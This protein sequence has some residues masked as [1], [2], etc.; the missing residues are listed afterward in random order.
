MDGK[1]LLGI[2]VIGVFLN[3]GFLFFMPEALV[4]FPTALV[5]ILFEGFIIVD[6]VVRP[7]SSKRDE[8]RRSRIFTVSLFLL[9]PILMLLPI[10][11]MNILWNQYLTPYNLEL[12]VAIGLFILLFG[13]I[14]LYH[15]R[16]IIGRYGGSRI[17]IEDDHKIIT[18]GLYKYIRHPIYL[19]MLCLFAGY[20]I[21]LGSLVITSL[22]TAILFGVLRERMEQEED[23]L[24]ERF[25]EEYIAYM[26]RTRRLIPYL[27]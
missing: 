20:L 3:L 13:G 19:G 17:T 7:V 6:I 25:G 5:I 22:W 10:L 18:K 24:I 16:H 4:T 9:M 15:S 11:E 8:Y 12:I 2:P 26:T 27:Y 14:T 1:R 21:A 23:M